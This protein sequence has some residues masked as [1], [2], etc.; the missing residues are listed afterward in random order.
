[1]SQYPT[2]HDA[3][4]ARGLPKD[5][6]PPVVNQIARF[7]YQGALREWQGKQNAARTAW[8]ETTHAE[9]PGNADALEWTPIGWKP[10][11]YTVNLEERSRRITDLQQ[12]IRVLQANT[13]PSEADANEIAL[14]RARDL[15]EAKERVA[16]LGDEC[17]RLLELVSDTD[18]K[19][20]HLGREHLDTK[21][22]IVEAKSVKDSEPHHRCPH[23]DGGLLL[24]SGTNRIE[25]WVPPDGEAV[26]KAQGIVAAEEETMR[27][28]ETRRYVLEAESKRRQE[29]HGEAM[30]KLWKAQ[31]AVK[32]VE[33]RLEGLE[34][35]Q[36]SPAKTAEINDLKG[37]IEAVQKDT[38]LYTRWDEARKSV[39][40]YIHID[41]I[42]EAIGEVAA[43]AAVAS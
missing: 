41:Q 31:E 30:T 12:R 34:T 40:T 8:E 28:L 42:M 25:G 4:T 5:E 22:K 32:K 16:G 3:W 29:A 20:R 37:V 18:L 11:D 9:W 17:E 19:L 24:F 33:A 43:P 14:I 7:G 35:G 2:L 1:M 10:P 21:H 36:P 26:A 6:L 15:P 38:A 39:E 27:E 13:D 23:C